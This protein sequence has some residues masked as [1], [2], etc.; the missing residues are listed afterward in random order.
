[1]SDKVRLDFGKDDSMSSFEPPSIDS[2]KIHKT[3]E[4]KIEIHYIDDDESMEAL[5][6]KRPLFNNSSPV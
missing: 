1:M 6:S 4:H 3:K 2:P 5:D